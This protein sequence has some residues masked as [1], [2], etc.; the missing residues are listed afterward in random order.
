MS[1]TPEQAREIAELARL[2]LTNEE[3]A[4]FA[5]QL[6]SILDHVSELEACGDAEILQRQASTRES[7]PLRDDSPPPDALSR[8]PSQWAPAWN[9]GFFTVPRLSAMTAESTGQED[10][11]A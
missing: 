7:T 5:T 4:R 11:G 1:V 8:S 2:R 3:I 10:A 9:A 6:A